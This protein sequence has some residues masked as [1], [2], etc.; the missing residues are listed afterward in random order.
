M[1]RWLGLADPGLLALILRRSSASRLWPWPS[2]RHWSR[3]FPG[4]LP[5]A[6]TPRSFAWPWLIE[7]RAIAC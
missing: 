5:A 6:L 2:A 1:E 3:I 4:F 7:Q